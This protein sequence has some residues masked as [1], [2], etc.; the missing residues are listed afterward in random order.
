MSGYAVYY[1]WANL[2]SPWALVT[3]LSEQALST[4]R[5]V[6]VEETDKD[7][8]ALLK[9]EMTSELGVRD[10]QRLA[11]LNYII[12]SRRG[13]ASGLAQRCAVTLARSCADEMVVG[14]DLR[15]TLCRAL[16]DAEP[17]KLGLEG[18]KG[19][20]QLT[21]AWRPGDCLRWSDRLPG[22]VVKSLL[23]HLSLALR[24]ARAMKDGPLRGR[25]LAEAHLVKGRLLCKAGRLEQ[26]EKELRS[27]LRS[28]AAVDADGA[29]A[30][31]QSVIW[32]ALI[33]LYVLQNR[34]DDVFAAMR[35][36]DAALGREEQRMPPDV[37]G[38]VELEL[39]A[40]RLAA[41]QGRTKTANTHQRKALKIIGDLRHTHPTP[42]P[43]Q[44][45][46]ITAGLFLQE[47]I[48]LEERP[49]NPEDVLCAEGVVEAAH[50]GH[51]GAKS[52][53][54]LS[55]PWMMQRP[56]AVFVGKKNTTGH[57]SGPD[58][59]L[60][61]ILNADRVLAWRRIDELI[62][63]LG[64]AP[65]YPEGCRRAVEY[66][67]CVMLLQR[68]ADHICY[69]KPRSDPSRRTIWTGDLRFRDFTVEEVNLL[70]DVVHR[71]EAPQM[72][73][74]D[75]GPA[76][77][78]EGTLNLHYPEADYHMQAPPNDPADLCVK[79]VT[80][81]SPSGADEDVWI[82]EAFNRLMGA[83]RDDTPR[84]R[85]CHMP[86]PEGVEGVEVEDGEGSPRK[87]CGVFYIPERQKATCFRAACEK[88]PRAYYS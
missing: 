35:E 3:S 85:R 49:R 26:G 86:P 11:A 81:A 41:Q 19:A 36:R 42:A 22:A 50:A 4:V 82:W 74:I 6:D 48:A 70:R 62:A 32:G 87:I 58:R 60:L 30:G 88:A 33:D 66:Y 40:S 57:L 53:V 76:H 67:R 56:E 13:Y 47:H 10:L 24:I 37:S 16:S 38:A 18:Y 59:R 78:D 52:V 77:A 73:M 79:T 14:R 2:G 83:A 8:R 72:Y 80:V 43:P 39:S 1:I 69:I 65:A 46:P 28:A 45:E 68:M 9:G 15:Q 20:M 54:Q 31:L 34:F 12:A 17:S 21:G 61:L 64:G 51:E 29:L 75:A 71:G 84:L 27:A 5:R 23:K 7:L 44:Y 63:E 25:A 55:F